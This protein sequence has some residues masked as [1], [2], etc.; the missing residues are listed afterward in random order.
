MPAFNLVEPVIILFLFLVKFYIHIF[1]KFYL[2]H[3]LKSN[4]HNIIF[5]S[6]FH[7]GYRKG[8]FPLAANPINISFAFKLLFYNILVDNMSSSAF[9]I[10]S[11]NAPFPPAIKYLILL[12]ASRWYNSTPS[13]TAILP[14]DPAPT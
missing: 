10:E 2:Q 1:L 12:L 3:C 4:S 7:H 6:F 9:S 13:C 11:T 14:D 5:F 8:V